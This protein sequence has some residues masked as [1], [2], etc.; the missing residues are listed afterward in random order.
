MKPFKIQVKRIHF[1]NGKVSYEERWRNTS[2]RFDT[3]KAAWKGK[4]ELDSKREE[5][6]KYR[7]IEND[8]S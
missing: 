2:F 1:F 4:R 3:E 7:V 5:R 6:F 8:V